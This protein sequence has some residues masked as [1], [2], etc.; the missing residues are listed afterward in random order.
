MH[1]VERKQETLTD[2]FAE[3][4]F[5][6]AGKIRSFPDQIS[7]EVRSK[8]EIDNDE[9]FANL[10][11]RIVDE[12]ITNQSPKSLAKQV[13]EDIGISHKNGPTEPKIFNGHL[14]HVGK[15]ARKISRKQQDSLQLRV[16]RVKRSTRGPPPNIRRMGA[17]A[18]TRERPAL[19]MEYELN[20]SARNNFNHQSKP[21]RKR[22]LFRR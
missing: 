22:R 6:E 19:G 21:K 15:R 3:T 13:L 12:V 4:V 7:L 5:Q 20:R 10:A 17:P 11:N 2:N 14:R 9:S 8:P 18:S 16:R 1:Y